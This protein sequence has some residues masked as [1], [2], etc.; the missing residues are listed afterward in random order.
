[1]QLQHLCRFTLDA[2]I[3]N[4]LGRLPPGLHTLYSEIYDYLSTTPGELQAMVFKNVLRWLLCAQ[5]TLHT[6]EFLA[7]VSIDPRIEGDTE[8]ISKDLVLEICNNFVV[9]DAQLDTFR[10]AHLSVR[11]FLERQPGYDMVVANGLIA[12]VCIWSVLSIG[13]NS[14][15]EGLFQQHKLCAKP[16]PAR[17]ELLRAYADM[18]W[19]SHCK[20]AEKERG[21]GELRS[22]LQHLLCNAN[23]IPILKLWSR[24]LE[25]YLETN[26]NW[27]IAMQLED[28][29]TTA[30]M[31]SSIGLFVCC[32]FDFDEQLEDVLGDKT[33]ETLYLNIIGRN[34]LNVA[35]RHG[36][37]ATLARLISKSGVGTKLPEE[38]V[39]AAAGSYNGKGVMA[40]L[41]DWRAADVMITEEVVDAAARN[42]S[43]GKEV[44]TLL[45]ERQGV[46]A[47]IP[48]EMVVSI[49]E[50]FDQ[51]V[52]ALLLDQRGADVVITEEVAASSRYN[53]KE[54]IALLLDRRGAEIVITEDVLKAAASNSK[55]VMALLLDR[56]GAEVVITEEVVKAAASSYYNGKEV[57]ALLLDRRGA[58]F[59]ITEE[60]LKATAGNY[61]GKEKMT[62]LLDRRG[63][64]IVI[65]E[66]VLKAAVDNYNGKEI[67]ALLLDR[68]GAEIVMTEEVLKTAAG[69]PNGSGIIRYLHDSTDLTITE[70]V[71]E[72]AA[73]SGQ[74]GTLSLLAE[75][76]STV[77]VTHDWVCIA[78][79]CAAARAGHAKTVL[80]LVQQGT[81]PDKK[82][83]RGTTP[84]WYASSLGYTD[85]VQVLLATK[86][87]DV[88]VESVSQRTPIFWAAAC[89]FVEIVK[90]LL[91]HGARQDYTDVDGKSPLA[92]AQLQK[93]GIV[94]DILTDHNV[95]AYAANSKD[96]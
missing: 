24:R 82:D 92:I 19:T 87:V 32:V 17:A 61:N 65:T 22:L 62:L 73:T 30:E 63:A 21:L 36:S 2:D 91:A 43:N 4:S 11:E 80:Q 42:H 9:F 18:Y 27:E 76:P 49:V 71:I 56:R 64:E 34:H 79:L 10:F 67:M 12:E 29:M 50:N 39:V 31:V 57:I 51:S 48:K 1:M 25:I 3:Q 86:A 53:G 44:I 85:V 14:A 26:M 84:L 46:E 94:S 59:V 6:D 88:N 37:C 70:T 52:V 23:S 66:E 41:L 35:A 74:E 40:L 15:T 5:R 47:A 68:R 60:V 33:S 81:P 89:G 95:T 96:F 77:S 13:G 45:L 20:S 75:W 78:Q 83:I 54:V 38:V 7:I 28:T 90:L 16:T 8:S 69:N 93:Q 72:S 55:E 58:E